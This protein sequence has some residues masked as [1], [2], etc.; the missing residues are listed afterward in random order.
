MIVRTNGAFGSGRTAPVENLRGR[1]PEALAF[2]PED[3]GQVLGRIVD[4]PTGNV[5]DLPL[6]MTLVDPRYGLLPGQRLVDE[7]LGR[8]DA[9][10]PA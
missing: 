5:Q 2:D 9:R 7:A 10:A 3:I 1:L 8:L 6:W 4:V